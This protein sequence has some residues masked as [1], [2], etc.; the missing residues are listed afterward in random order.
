MHYRGLDIGTY[1]AHL[2]L[3]QLAADLVHIRALSENPASAA[4]CGG[5]D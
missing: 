4:A 2:N 5:F 3:E 1:L